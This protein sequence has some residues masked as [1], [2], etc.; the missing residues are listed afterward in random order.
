MNKYYGHNVQVRVGENSI[1][2]SGPSPKIVRAWTNSFDLRTNVNAE[3]TDS[4][5]NVYS[6]DL[7]T[8]A[9]EAEVYFKDEL[10][11]AE[12]SW[13]ELQVAHGTLKKA[14]LIKHPLD[15]GKNWARTVHPYDI[16]KSSGDVNS[17]NPNSYST[18]IPIWKG[19]ELYR[20]SND[21]TH[22]AEGEQKLKQDFCV[23]FDKDTRKQT[24][25]SLLM[26][27]D[28]LIDSQIGNEGVDQRVGTSFDTVNN[29]VNIEGSKYGIKEENGQWAGNVNLTLEQY[30]KLRLLDPGTVFE[31]TLSSTLRTGNFLFADDKFELTEEERTEV[32][33]LV[34]LIQEAKKE[35]EKIIAEFDRE[36]FDQEWDQTEADLLQARDAS[37]PADP[38]DPDEQ[39]L[40]DLRAEAESEQSS[41]NDELDLHIEQVQ[42]QQEVIG[43]LEKRYFEILQR[44]GLRPSF[45]RT[46]WRSQGLSYYDEFNTYDPFLSTPNGSVVDENGNVDGSS[47]SPDAQVEEGI[48]PKALAYSDFPSH[49]AT[50]AGGADTAKQYK[51]YEFNITDVVHAHYQLGGGWMRFAGYNYGVFPFPHGGGVPFWQ[52]VDRSLNFKMPVWN[53]E[54]FVIQLHDEIPVLERRGE[55]GPLCVNG[56]VGVSAKCVS[57]SQPISGQRTDVNFTDLNSFKVA[58]FIVAPY[59]GYWDHIEDLLG[60]LPGGLSINTGAEFG[61]FE[62]QATYEQDGSIWANYDQSLREQY[63]TDWTGSF[64]YDDP[65]D[66]AFNYVLGNLNS[67]YNELTWDIFFLQPNMMH[68]AYIVP[69]E[70]AII[71][72]SPFEKPDP[73]RNLGI[74][75]I[76]SPPTNLKELFRPDRPQSLDVK[77]S[78]TVP[79]PQ[80]RNVQLT[81]ENL[82]VEVLNLSNQNI[83]CNSSLDLSNIEVKLAD[84]LLSSS[85]Y[86]VSVSPPTEQWNSTNGSNAVSVTF[87]TNL[88]KPSPPTLTSITYLPN[89]PYAPRSLREELKKPDRPRNLERNVFLLPEEYAI[90][91]TDSI[92]PA[93]S[94][95]GTV[96]NVVA[97]TRTVDLV[98]DSSWSNH[99]FILKCCYN[100]SMAL[101][102]KDNLPQTKYRLQVSGDNSFGSAGIGHYSLINYIWAYVAG[103]HAPESLLEGGRDRTYSRYDPQVL[104]DGGYKWTDIVTTEAG[105]GVNVFAEARNPFQTPVTA[106]IE[107]AVW[108]KTWWNGSSP[109]SWVLQ[110]YYAPPK[111]FQDNAGSIWNDVIK[112]PK[113]LNV[114]SGARYLNDYYGTYYPNEEYFEE[115]V[116]DILVT[117]NNSYLIIEGEIWG[118]GAN[119]HSQFGFTSTD[120]IYYTWKKLTLNTQE[121]ITDMS[122]YKD[123]I[124]YVDSLGDLYGSGKYSDGQISN[125]VINQGVSKVCSAYTGY[126]YI[127][128][129]D[130]TVH[131]TKS[132]LN[133]WEQ[134]ATNVVDISCGFGFALLLKDDEKVYSHGDNHSGQRGL[135]HF[136]EVSEVTYTGLDNIHSIATGDYHC[137]VLD[138]YGSVFI[139]GSNSHGQI[140]NGSIFNNNSATPRLRIER[141]YSFGNY[142][143]TNSMERGP[144]CVAIMAGGNSTFYVNEELS[145]GSSAGTFTLWGMGSNYYGQMGINLP[146]S[147]YLYTNET[148]YQPLWNGPILI[149]TIYL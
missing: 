131:F 138:K 114:P 8:G 112:G 17:A 87:A 46:L 28:K 88:E 105:Y 7:K 57:Y 145:R 65:D 60:Y 95:I 78:N 94:T 66:P 134:I 16:F 44:A 54:G 59:E 129:T 29:Q 2:P 118:R 39:A 96:S 109:E 26:V 75:E 35:L 11:E 82:E 58:D 34:L 62:P 72:D 33:G 64:N 49:E 6:R 99:P 142:S 70:E 74:N 4:S 130:G 98:S 110:N 63:N 83:E 139:W 116:D 84:R 111:T 97:S 89:K 100:R 107:D 42:A 123:F 108:T 135:G 9:T 71:L 25:G 119:N 125:G 73:P 90:A 137:V 30:Q 43:A 47:V 128:K 106:T 55:Y 92:Y 120:D 147:Y 37:C 133:S 12:I 40:C 103:G 86:S 67:F 20:P 79:P 14:K 38:D 31:A 136:D 140:D 91:P 50:S 77:G 148:S 13:A 27:D 104:A 113:L 53:D 56:G 51:I 21:N 127:L 122:G 126:T 69:T 121:P 149:Q 45:P 41:L 36:N 19:L 32:D 18:P 117:P 5:G 52:M 23:Y 48:W 3:I 101:F 22:Y 143:N 1:D 61:G 132:D 141:T 115:E 15:T 24:L 124:L 93:T 102:K 80:P 81:K 144:K 10:S 76:P 85:E 146:L 68:D